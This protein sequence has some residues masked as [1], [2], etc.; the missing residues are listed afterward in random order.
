MTT[1]TEPGLEADAPGLE[2]GEPSLGAGGVDLDASSPGA[3]ESGLEAPGVCAACGAALVGPYCHA[4]GERR[5]RP[6][7]ESLGAFLREQFHEV[8]SADGRMW[9]TFRALPVPGKLTDEHFSGRRGLYLRPVRLF[10]VVNVVFFLVLTFLGGQAFRGDA[11]LYRANPVYAGPMEVAAEREGVSDEAY[12]AAFGRHADT[13]SRTLV[14]LFVPLC[15]F[16]LA[17][18]LLPAR[19]PVV[20]HV[21][22]ATHFVVVFMASTVVVAGVLLAVQTLWEAVSGPIPFVLGDNVVVPVLVLLWVVYLVAAIRR[23]YAVPWWGA[24]VAG[25]LVGT[26]GTLLMMQ[27][28]RVILF[29]VTLWTLDVPA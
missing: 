29:Y 3:D 7:D 22:F 26:V 15:A 2:A 19:P 24:A 5:P 8:T 9:R 1:P 12:D 13:L 10:L 27:A 18:V 6:D 14:V 4:C 11:A 20:R 28:Y 25:G 23:V 17:V 21:V 16:A